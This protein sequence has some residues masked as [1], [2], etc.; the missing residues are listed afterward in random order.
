MTNDIVFLISITN[1]DFLYRV[2][3]KIKRD[4][5][6]DAAE[7][8]LEP[9]NKEKI[10]KLLPLHVRSCGKIVEVEEIFEVVDQSRA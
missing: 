2:A 1:G 6:G 3:L 5:L 4:M 8:P 7:Y 9:E 10:M